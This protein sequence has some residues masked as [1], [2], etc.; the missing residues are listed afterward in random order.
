MAWCL[1]HADWP[2]HST[3]FG[4]PS[5]HRKCCKMAEVLLHC[6]CR[7][8]IGHITSEMDSYLCYIMLYKSYYMMEHSHIRSL[9]LA[10]MG[11]VCIRMQSY[12]FWK[13][14]WCEED[15]MAKCRSPQSSQKGTWSDRFYRLIWVLQYLDSWSFCQKI[16]FR[17]R[18]PTHLARDRTYRP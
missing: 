10:G 8:Y 14:F 7:G 4:F 5:S 17:P 13:Y 15:V 9:S 12:S 1:P 11:N 6:V 18:K 16:Y 2:S 3:S